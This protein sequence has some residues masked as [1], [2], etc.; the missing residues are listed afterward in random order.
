MINQTK[1]CW[2]GKL[3]LSLLSLATMSGCMT[4]GYVIQDFKKAPRQ[5][6]SLIYAGTKYHQ[7]EIPLYESRDRMTMGDEIDYALRWVHYIDLPL[8]LCADTVLLPYTIPRTQYSRRKIR[9]SKEEIAI[10]PL[11]QEY[12]ACVSIMS[13]LKCQ[14]EIY[15]EMHNLKPSDKLPQNLDIYWAH[16]KGFLFVC[17]AGG[18]YIVGAQTEEPYCSIHGT[19]S[20]AKATLDF[21]YKE[22]RLPKPISK[23]TAKEQIE[24]NMINNNSKTIQNMENK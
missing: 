14:K 9:P 24:Q 18:K 4:A 11:L 8:C 15:A 22:H 13:S 19:L 7:H 6:K 2:V 17:P 21:I 20:E 23:S 16:K 5:R 12:H 1:D 3:I 10:R